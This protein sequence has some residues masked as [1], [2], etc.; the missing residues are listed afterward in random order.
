MSLPSLCSL[1]FFI[2]FIVDCY[3]TSLPFDTFTLPLN[4]VYLHKQIKLHH[5]LDQIKSDVSFKIL[6]CLSQH[7]SSLTNCLLPASLRQKIARNLHTHP[8]P[9]LP[10]SLVLYLATYSSLYY[11]LL[12][13][14]LLLSSSSIQN[15]NSSSLSISFFK[16]IIHILL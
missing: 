14:I 2:N 12:A 9:I 10:I 13:S 6:G 11:H 1:T 3:R 4:S 7:L 8:H 16:D 15:T 5:I